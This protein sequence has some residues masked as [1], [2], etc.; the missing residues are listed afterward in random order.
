[1]WNK[2][3]KYIIAF[4]LGIAGA[5]KAY[6][7][8]SFYRFIFRHRR[9]LGPLF[10]CA[11]I[12][13]LFLSPY[14][15]SAVMHKSVKYTFVVWQKA[16][17][18]WKNSTYIMARWEGEDPNNQ[19]LEEGMV[20]T[21]RV[22]CKEGQKLETREYRVFCDGEFLGSALRDVNSRN[23]KIH[24]FVFNGEIPRGKLFL[25]GDNSYSYDSRY[26]GFINTSQ[27]FGKV[28]FGI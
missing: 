7:N 5:Y 23:Q 1:V 17:E 18:A 28:V 22:G 11:F 2:F 15:V 21:K 26:F 27:V 9:I 4:L 19:G 3:D 10:G 20:L 14:H 8:S 13:F 16:E 6:M 24:Q 25:M 12:A